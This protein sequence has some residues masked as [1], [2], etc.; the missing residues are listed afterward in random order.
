MAAFVKLA[1]I[2]APIKLY[3]FSEFNLK[4]PLTCMTQLPLWLALTFIQTA[5]IRN[6]KK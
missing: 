4:M 6:T 2:P 5:L 3:S 1:F